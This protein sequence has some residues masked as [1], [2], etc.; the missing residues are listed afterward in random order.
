[1]CRLAAAVEG[2]ARILQCEVM[3]VA[4]PPKANAL[5]DGVHARCGY[6]VMARA[7]LPSVW[8]EVADELAPHVEQVFV[9]PLR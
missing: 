5:W 4:F 3:L 8:R 2:E 1:M 7:Q 6:K 9:K